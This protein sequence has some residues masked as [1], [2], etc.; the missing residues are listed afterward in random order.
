MYLEKFVRNPSS[1]LTYVFSI[2]ISYDFRFSAFEIRMI[3]ESNKSQQNW[4]KFV[5]I[6]NEYWKQTGY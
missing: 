1:Y 2:E 6:R 4:I 5:I 3:V